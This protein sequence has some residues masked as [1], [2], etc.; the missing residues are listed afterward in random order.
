MHRIRQVSPS[1]GAIPV[2]AQANWLGTPQ[3]ADSLGNVI[4]ARAVSSLHSERGIDALH[5]QTTTS[6]LFNR[7]YPYAGAGIIDA[8]L[9][10]ASL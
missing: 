4:L 7:R 8:R 3:I 10:S 5:I 9:S 2:E 6:Q 1:P